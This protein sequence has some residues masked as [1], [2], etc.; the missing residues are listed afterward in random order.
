MLPESLDRYEFPDGV[1]WS[2]TPA[3]FGE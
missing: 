3:I 1:A 2:G